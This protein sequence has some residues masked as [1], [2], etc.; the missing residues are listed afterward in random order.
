MGAH[1]LDSARNGFTLP[2]VLISV[3]ISL[4][5]VSAAAA[6][7]RFQLHTLRTQSVQVDLQSLGR[8]AVELFAREARNAGVNANNTFCAL[9][10]ARSDR[11]RFKSDFDEDGATTTAG[12]DISYRLIGDDNQVRRIDHNLSGNDA[13]EVLI[14]DV[15]AMTFTVAYFDASGNTLDPGTSGL[16]TAQRSL[17]RRIRLTLTLT[18]T[19]A[20]P[21]DPTSVQVREVAEV[22]IRNR[23]YAGNDLDKPAC[24]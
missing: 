18:A 16:T 21:S 9:A 20:D 22:D 11:I 4:L 12:E 3:F 7:N 10:E 8:A 1:Q 13:T 2:E 23:F 15:D 24:T 19:S 6:F 5:V 14:D 17:V